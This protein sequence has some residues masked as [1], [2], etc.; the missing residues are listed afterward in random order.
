M[1][2]KRKRGQQMLDLIIDIGYFLFGFT[3]T[4]G[5]T[6]WLFELL[7]MAIRGK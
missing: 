6:Y 7:R 3:L 5:L 2:A 1:H 4:V